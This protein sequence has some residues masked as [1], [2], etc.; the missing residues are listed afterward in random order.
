MNAQVHKSGKWRKTKFTSMIVHVV[1]MIN[2]MK[3]RSNLPA[4]HKKMHKFTKV[5]S[6][7]KNKFHV[8]DVTGMSCQ[9]AQCYEA[10]KVSYL[11][12]IREYTR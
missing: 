4:E 12:S 6:G 8:T 10:A 7:E 9:N 5:A 3:Q 11:L 2:A 1:R